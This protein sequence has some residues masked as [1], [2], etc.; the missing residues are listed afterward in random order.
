MKNLCVRALAVIAGV[1]IIGVSVGLFKLVELGADSYTVM[2]TAIS[3]YIGMQFGT[4]QLLINIGIMVFV[5]L[6]KREFIGFGTIICMVFVGYTADFLM[7]LLADFRHVF[8]YGAVRFPVL[9]ISMMLLGAGVALYV[10]ADMGMSPYD[11][12]AYIIESLTKGKVSSQAGRISVDIL[13]LTIGFFFG[14]QTGIQW[15]IIGI[16]T[17]LLAFATGPLIQFFRTHWTDKLLAGYHR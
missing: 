10:S 9:L 11:S 4:L 15:K 3:T 12:L 1:F 16:G 5:I 7:W 6:F 14:I 17:V 2:N 13:T 8:T